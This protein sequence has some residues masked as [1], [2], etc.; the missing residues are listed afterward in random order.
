[1]HEFH[2]LLQLFLVAPLFNDDAIED[3][4]TQ[5]RSQG[6]TTPDGCGNNS[7]NIKR[8]LIGRTEKGRSLGAGSDQTCF[9]YRAF[10]VDDNVISTSYMAIKATEGNLGGCSQKKNF[11]DCIPYNAGECLFANIIRKL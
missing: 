3:P 10:H 2:R 5:S 6:E 11:R 8:V 7:S 1:M 9:D 4:T